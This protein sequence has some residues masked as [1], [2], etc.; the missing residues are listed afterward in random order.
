MG[1]DLNLRFPVL[2]LTLLLFAAGAAPARADVFISPFAGITFGSDP[3]CPS[4][5]VCEEERASIGAAVGSI[6]N[7]LGF[8][9]EA[10]YT[11]NFFGRGPGFESNVLTLMSSIVLVPKVGPLRPYALAGVGLVST[12]LSSAPL[13]IRDLDSNNL[14]WNLGGGLMVLF[15]EHIGIRGDVRAIELFQDLEFLG[16]PIEDTKLNFGRA[17]VGLVLRF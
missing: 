17:N 11:E 14:A 8:E 1:C 2:G 5:T 13:N 16:F 12:Q 9:I 6:G 4:L 3:A 7:V 10:S 15:G